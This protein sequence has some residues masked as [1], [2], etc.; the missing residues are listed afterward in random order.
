MKSVG[1]AEWESPG[2]PSSATDDHGQGRQIHYLRA[3]PLM[4]FINS[5]SVTGSVSFR[6]DVPDSRLRV[7]VALLA[8]CTDGGSPASLIGAKGLN[9]WLRATEDSIETGDPA[10]I[11]NLWGTGAQPAPIPGYIDPQTGLYAADANLGGW[12]KEFV[13]IGNAIVGTVNYPGA[14]PT[15]AGQLVLQVRYIPEAIRFPRDEWDE[16]RRQCGRKILGLPLLGAA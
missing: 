1:G 7:N 13:T 5:G 10:P 2:S 4:T 9:M 16:I 8:Q 15:G 3:L 14:D 11:T 6:V 12:G